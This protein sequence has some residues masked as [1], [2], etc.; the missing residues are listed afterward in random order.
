MRLLTILK[1]CLAV[2]IAASTGCAHIGNTCVGIRGSCTV[3]RALKPM[4]PPA[5]KDPVLE[6]FYASCV[7]D[8]PLLICDYSTYPTRKGN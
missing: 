3:Y 8:G 7:K 2:L 1:P 6:E 4:M 5:V